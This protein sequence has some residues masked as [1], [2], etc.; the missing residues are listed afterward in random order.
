WLLIYG[1]TQAYRSTDTEVTS[2][3]AAT[4]RR[5]DSRR[6]IRAQGVPRLFNVRH[7]RPRAAAYRGWSEARAAANH[8][9]D[10]GARPQRNGEIQKIRAHRRR[11]HRQIS[12]ARRLRLLRGDGLA[13]AA[14]LDA[15]CA[16]RRAGKLGL[17]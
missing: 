17:A 4:R 6:A 10:V 15:L 5:A 2:T 3:P 8:L 1:R 11:R 16:H 9:R 7:P 14:V 12:S 13:G